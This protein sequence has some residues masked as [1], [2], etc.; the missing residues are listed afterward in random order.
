MNTHIEGKHYSFYRH[1]FH[2]HIF[3]GFSFFRH[4]WRGTTSLKHILTKY[5]VQAATNITNTESNH[6]LPGDFASNDTNTSENNSTASIPKYTK[7][8]GINGSFKKYV[9]EN[10]LKDLQDY[11]KGWDEDNQEFILVDD[12]S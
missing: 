12:K 8:I 4:R 6:T 7:I 10:V 9:A 11:E 3:F 1:K 5:P 2:P